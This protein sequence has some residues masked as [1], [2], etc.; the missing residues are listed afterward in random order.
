VFLLR[1]IGYERGEASSSTGSKG[2][3][4]PEKAKDLFY[5]LNKKIIK[6]E[7]EEEKKQEEREKRGEGRGFKRGQGGD[8]SGHEVSLVTTATDKRRVHP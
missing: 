7:K 1:A 5:L 8:V 4:S 3:W 2:K 6:R